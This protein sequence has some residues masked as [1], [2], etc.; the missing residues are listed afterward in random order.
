MGEWA[1]QVGGGE[2]EGGRGHPEKGSRERIIVR[3]CSPD[4]RI[5]RQ[6]VDDR[7]PSPT[8]ASNTT[9]LLQ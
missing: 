4:G 6:P 1:A 3:R 2:E 7:P 5:F 9:A 8:R